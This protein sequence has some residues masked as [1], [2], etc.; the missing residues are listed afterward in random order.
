[1]DPLSAVAI[2][3]FRYVLGTDVQAR[4]KNG[5]V[6]PRVVD[7]GPLVATL[8]IESDAPGCNRLIR[9]VRVIDGLDRV[10]LVNHVD[11]KPVR[12]KDAVHFGFGFLR[13]EWHRPHGDALGGGPAESGSIGGRVPQLVHR[14]T[15]GRCL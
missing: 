10:E 5:P 8:R 13:P 11:R 3:D 2:N 4:E 9:E 7:A 12:E 6:P 15:L 1:M 14:A